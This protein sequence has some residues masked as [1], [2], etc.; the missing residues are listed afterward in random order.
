MYKI[1]MTVVCFGLCSVL[2]VAKAA[3]GEGEKGTAY[4]TPVQLALATPIQIVPKTWDVKGFRL[5]VIYSYNNDVG[6][7]DAGIV[8]RTA[9]DEIGIQ[10][11]GI[12]NRVEGNVSGI[13]IAGIV[14]SV[15]GNS[16][17]EGMQIA[18]MNTVGD[19]SGLQTGVVNHSKTMQGVQIGVFNLTNELDGLQI[20]VINLN[21][22][23]SIPFMP[24]LN[25]GF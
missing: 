23:G 18:C 14:N 17:V 7:L 19:V 8:N 24:L 12:M 20:G 25:F 9:G 10:I 3:D 13:Q 11:G 6:F 22:S 2:S 4:W 15:G 16:L 1:L 21:T 5:G